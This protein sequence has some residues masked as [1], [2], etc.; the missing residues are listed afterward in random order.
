MGLISRNLLKELLI[1]RIVPVFEEFPPSSPFERLFRPEIKFLHFSHLL[2]AQN[3]SCIAQLWSKKKGLRLIPIYKDRFYL[4]SHRCSM[5]F[6]CRG[7]FDETFSPPTFRGIE[8]HKRLHLFIRG[9][10]LY[11]GEID[12]DW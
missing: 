12:Q 7:T 1:K 3:L 9:Q 10:R 4:C 2:R 11:W 8:E 5:Y 6:I